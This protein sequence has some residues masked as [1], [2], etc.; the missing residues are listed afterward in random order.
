MAVPSQDMVLG[1][2]YLTM[3]RENEKGAGKVFRDFNEA[4]MA[5]PVRCG[6]IA[7]PH[8]SP[9]LPEIGGTKVTKII[10]A[11]VG[12]IIFNDPIPRTWAMWTAPI[13]TSSLTWRSLS[14]SAKGAG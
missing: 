11:T 14:W 1:S 6:G 8:Q 2:Y 9:R 4:L 5:L 7:C 12:R 13:P 3:V 10:D